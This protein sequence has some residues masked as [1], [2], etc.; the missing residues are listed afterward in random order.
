MTSN[1]IVWQ[2]FPKHSPC[3]EGLR[4]VTQCFK[5]V[6]DDISSLNKA[7]EGQ[8]S[9]AV[10]RRVRDGLVQIG[11]NVESSKSKEGK[12]S[13]PVLFKE[14]GLVDRKFEADAYHPLEKIVLEVEAGRGVS[15]NQFL[16]DLF[17]ACVMQDVEYLAIAIR[18]DYRG[19][20]DYK[21]VVGFFDTVYAS[22]RLKLPLK[23][24][25]IVGY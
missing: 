15:N 4:L 11:F 22:N 12:L 6:V 18:Q 9:N 1:E 10:L 14:N 17:Q 25:L 21:K 7:N 2:H 16:K 3:P 20:N 13:I 8:E 5:D 19:H 23:G 24:I